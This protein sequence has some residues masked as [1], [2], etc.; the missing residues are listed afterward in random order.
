MRHFTPHLLNLLA[1]CTAPKL[2]VACSGGLDSMVLLHATAQTQIPFGV[3]HCNYQLR[4]TESDADEALVESASQ[5]KGAPFHCVRFD[6]KAI[7][8]HKN[9]GIQELARD[10]RYSWFAQLCEEQGYTHVLTAHHRNDHIETFFIN[11]LRGSGLRGLTGIPQQ[12]GNIIRPLLEVSKTELTQYAQEQGIQWREDASN[13]SLHYT[14]NWVRH[15]ITPILAARDA[16]WEKKLLVTLSNLQQTET[17]IRRV[18]D[19]AL[20]ATQLEPKVWNR[21]MIAG[22]PALPLICLHWLEEIALNSARLEELQ[23][24]CVSTESLYFKGHRGILALSG[25]KIFIRPLDTQQDHKTLLIHHWEE[26]VL[27][28][29]VEEVGLIT[30]AEVD[31]LAKPDQ[32]SAAFCWID[33]DTLD[34]PLRLET[35]KEGDRFYPLG[36]RGSK[37]ISDYFNELKFTDV[38]KQQ[39]IILRSAKNNII[40]ILCK[41]LDRRF[42]VTNTTKQVLRLRHLK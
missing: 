7:N 20:D 16:N 23:Q 2:L 4:G 29:G 15:S 1:P 30:P 18:V 38:E 8:K 21:G 10:L 17:W 39:P 9:T 35:Y 32:S 41:R 12:M 3:A 19:A 36:M 40:W 27:L 24:A 5:A 14:R 31:F 6:T 33:L 25:N 37:R 34:F 42:A 28:P 22:Q 26:L 13:S 11:A